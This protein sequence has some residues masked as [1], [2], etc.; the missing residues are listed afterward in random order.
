[1]EKTVS[2][3]N[4]TNVLIGHFLDDVLNK[5]DGLSGALKGTLGNFNLEEILN[6]ENIAKIVGFLNK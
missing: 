1:M 3:D 4:K 5:L 2:K 6:N